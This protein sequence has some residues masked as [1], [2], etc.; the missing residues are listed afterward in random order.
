MNSMFVN[1]NHTILEDFCNAERPSG[2]FIELIR[3][4]L[5]LA[6]LDAKPLLYMDTL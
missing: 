3:A 4:M 2:A 5:L 1:G 6:I